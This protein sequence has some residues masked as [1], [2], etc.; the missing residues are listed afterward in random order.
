MS[1]LDAVLLRN[2]TVTRAF[3]R[4]M[5]ALAPRL[6]AGRTWGGCRGTRQ[7]K[8]AGTSLLISI[9]AVWAVVAGGVAGAQEAPVVEDRSEHLA[10]EGQ[11]QLQ[12]GDEPAPSVPVG[13]VSDRL[14]RTHSDRE[15]SDFLVEHMDGIRNGYT[16]TLPDGTE[17][18]EAAGVAAAQPCQNGFTCVFSRSNYGGTRVAFVGQNNSWV[19]MGPVRNDMGSVENLGGGKARFYDYNTGSYWCMNSGTRASTVP[20]YAVD[21]MDLIYTHTGGAC[22]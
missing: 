14:S 3:D 10:D 16:V 12:A 15:I 19:D 18:T 2:T 17:F 4:L 20:S 7:G 1:R 11:Y 8:G 6:D 9:L 13:G 22:T 5:G 21:Q